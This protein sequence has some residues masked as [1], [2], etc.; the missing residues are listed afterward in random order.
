[1]DLPRR[2]RAALAL[3]LGHAALLA[4]PILWTAF[5]PLAT[6][7]ATAWAGLVLE[8][9]LVA[10]VVLRRQRDFWV[11][12]VA[13][14]AMWLLAH[15]ISAVSQLPGVPLLAAFTATALA[16]PLILLSAPVRRLVPPAATSERGQPAASSTTPSSS[17]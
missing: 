10:A 2:D 1:M 11:A 14:D 5:H 12:L 13:L 16:R 8:V 15:A 7:S 17:A 4:G 9:V 3:L 6:V